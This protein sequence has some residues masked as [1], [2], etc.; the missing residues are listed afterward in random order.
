MGR[1][2]PVRPPHLQTVITLLALARD[3]VTTLAARLAWT[4]PATLAR[5]DSRPV[6]VDLMPCLSPDAGLGAAAG[7]EMVTAAVRQ[8]RGEPVT[9]SGPTWQPTPITASRYHAY[10]HRPHVERPVSV[11]IEV[12]PSCQR[13]LSLCGFLPSN[14]VRRTETIGL[15]A[16]GSRLAEMTSAGRALANEFIDATGSLCRDSSAQC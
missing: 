3:P 8:A 5:I 6:I 1:P 9:P 13:T 16:S 2:A 12:C 11:A 10:Q 4:G 7:A 14:S 15:W